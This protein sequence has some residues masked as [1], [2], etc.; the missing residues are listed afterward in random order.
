MTRTVLIIIQTLWQSHAICWHVSCRLVAI[1]VQ[2][3]PEL[4][5]Y[6]QSIGGGTVHVLQNLMIILRGHLVQLPPAC[7][8]AS[9]LR[10]V[11][12]MTGMLLQG[13]LGKPGHT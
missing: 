4:W 5:K 8:H 1:R 13:G 7:A 9:S 11:W 3:P 12:H 2:R 10:L 6:Y